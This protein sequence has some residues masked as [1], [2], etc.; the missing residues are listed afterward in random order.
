M[1]AGTWAP[2]P[3]SWISAIVSPQASWLSLGLGF[4]L[5]NCHGCLQLSPSAWMRAGGWS[6]SG[7]WRGPGLLGLG[8]CSQSRRQG[9]PPEQG[10]SCP[11]PHKDRPHQPAV[12][13]SRGAS[14]V[15]GSNPHVQGP[16]GSGR[17]CRAGGGPGCPLP[18]EHLQ[19]YNF[20]VH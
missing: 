18:Q 12:T 5:T 2:I 14:V 8:A 15:Q 19:N 16:K 1:V 13:Q 6:R 7:S 20:G 9:S 4:P 10:A 11:G 3:P 17:T